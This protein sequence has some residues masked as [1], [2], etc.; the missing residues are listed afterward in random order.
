MP[1]M[2]ALICGTNVIL[3]DIPVFK[4]IYNGF[5]VTFFKAQNADELAAK[6]K[7]KFS[8]PAP[9]SIPQKYS[10]EKTSDIILE[11]LKKYCIY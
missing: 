7:E 6:I 1:P 4:E 8:A 3:S 2:E 11:S 9:S 5:P 10:F